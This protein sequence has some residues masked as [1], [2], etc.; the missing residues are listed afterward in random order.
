MRANLAM[1]L[2]EGSE[3][4]LE[5][6]VKP[7]CACS[8]VYYSD[9]LRQCSCLV[10]TSWLEMD[11]EGRKVPAHLRAAWQSRAPSVRLL[12][13]NPGF[14]GGEETEC[15]VEEVSKT[16]S[17]N[18]WILCFKPLS[19]AVRFVRSMQS[20][21]TV[22][23][24]L[25]CGPGA[26]PKPSYT[27]DQ[28]AFVH[29]QCQWGPCPMITSAFFE[30]RSKPSQWLLFVADQSTS[31]P[32]MPDIPRT[33]D[34]TKLKEPCQRAKAVAIAG[35]HEALAWGL[36]DMC[37]PKS[38]AGSVLH[39]PDCAI[40]LSETCIVFRFPIVSFALATYRM[41][42]ARRDDHTRTRLSC[43]LMCGISKMR[44]SLVRLPEAHSGRA[45]IPFFEDNSNKKLKLEA[46]AKG[47][48]EAEAKGE[49][50]EGKA[51]G[52]VEGEARVRARAR[53]RI[54]GES[55]GRGEE[56]NIKIVGG[57][58]ASPHAASA[59]AAAEALLFTY[60]RDIV[61]P[62]DVSTCRASAFAGSAAGSAG[63]PVGLQFDFGEEE[64]SAGEQ[65]PFGF[66]NECP[67]NDFLKESRF[68]W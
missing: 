60:S 11:S 56:V 14:D 19:H 50:G 15:A 17:K 65:L 40:R 44:G 51:E 36:P 68:F 57:R 54:E 30:L 58:E 66:Q 48:V 45:F 7:R 37:S 41:A 29:V 23:S 47:E 18:R 22:D 20:L 16:F 25:T 32:P 34:K 53:A 43:Y 35:F 8:G 63:Q 59:A 21:R 2:A 10:V 49:E 62:V 61:L 13:V 6:C 27:N 64:F 52:E 4:C 12:A 26:G 24:M 38:P 28:K 39:M 5:P 55:E 3:R 1:K 33:F 46:E 42:N 31:L 67:D 9:D